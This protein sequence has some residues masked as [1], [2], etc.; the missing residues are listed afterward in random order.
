[1][2]S[3]T[4]RA[5]DFAVSRSRWAAPVQA[6]LVGVAE[7]VSDEFVGQRRVARQHAGEAAQ[8]S[9]PQLHVLGEVHARIPPCSS[10][11]IPYMLAVAGM[12]HAATAYR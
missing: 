6:T 3:R 10:D 12:L 4:L 7:Y 5:I 11:Y 8:R 9:A 2:A 1:V